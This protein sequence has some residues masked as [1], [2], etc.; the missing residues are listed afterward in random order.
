[1]IDTYDAATA[2]RASGLLR[3]TGAAL[4][5]ALVATLGMAAGDAA[6]AGGPFAGMGGSWAGSG[7]VATDGGVK[8]RLRCTA[9][10][11]VRDDD[12]NLQ[13]TLSCSSASYELKVNTYVNHAG[14]SLSGYWEELRNNVRGTVAGS[15][16]GNSV[17]VLLRGSGFSATLNLV[18][19]GRT[20]SVVV[21]PGS[22]SQ[23]LFE[24]VAVTLRKSG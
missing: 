8:E 18:T 21:T 6:L 14:G 7:T 4:A 1:M 15:A 11:L 20:Q 2:T 16:R 3:R 22:E 5:L 23:T 12:N 24:R 10:Y 17:R 13:Q 9:Q 19:R